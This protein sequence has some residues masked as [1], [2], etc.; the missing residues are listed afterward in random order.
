[1][2]WLSFL[3]DFLP[4]FENVFDDLDVLVGLQTDILLSTVENHLVRKG[5]KSY[6]LYAIDVDWLL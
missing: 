1:L 3:E 2:H 4:D 5:R 6:Q